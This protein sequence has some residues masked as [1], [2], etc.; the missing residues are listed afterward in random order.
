MT[1]ASS[2]DLPPIPASGVAELGED[3]LDPELVALHQPPAA[4][5]YVTLL[6]MGLVA[7]AAVTL[8]LS[9]RYPVAYYFSRPEVQDLGSATQLEPA[10]L[11]PNT[12]VRV[13]GAP[14]WSA[15]V[16]YSRLLLGGDHEIFPL[17]GQRR[18]FVSRPL[19]AEVDT[20]ATEFSGRLVTFRQLGARYGGLREHLANQLELPV[21]ADTFVLLAGEPPESYGWA[22]WLALL[23]L[24]ALVVDVAL[25]L[26]WFRPIRLEVERG[27]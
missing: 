27:A 23:G 22:L 1:Q 18:L 11:V 20:G 13:H 19:G 8:L 9:L 3:G 21:S 25:M 2:T 15:T 10:T 12:Q 24:L 6:V 4:R 7:A 17:A 14:M 16:R 26:R 5:R